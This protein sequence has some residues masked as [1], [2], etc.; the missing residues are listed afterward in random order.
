[1]TQKPAY[2]AVDCSLTLAEGLAEFAAADPGLLPPGD[3]ELRE[4]IRAHDACHVLFG[5]GTSVEDEAV[6]DTWTIFGSDIGLRRYASYL[7]HPEIAGLI[8]QIGG[9]RMTV[10]SARALPRVLRAIARA[11]RMRAPWPFFAYAQAL[12]VPI[13]ALRRRYGVRPV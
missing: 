13:A 6:A 8:N 12:D 2:L 1:M 9:W 7:K 3:G 5:L 11:R 10:G 4:F